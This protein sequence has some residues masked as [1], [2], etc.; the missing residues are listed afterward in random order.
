MAMA[1]AGSGRRAAG[2]LGNE[3][4]KE[5][6]LEDQEAVH[7]SSWFTS[8]CHGVLLLLLPAV[9]PNNPRIVFNLP[10][11]DRPPPPPRAQLRAAQ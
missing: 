10:G 4:D 2:E 5:G 11:V 8:P 7:T 3:G 1:T 6:S 9:G